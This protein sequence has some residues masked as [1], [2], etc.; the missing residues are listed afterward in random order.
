[1][2]EYAVILACYSPRATWRWWKR[3]LLGGL[4]LVSVD[5]LIFA[6]E[7]GSRAIAVEEADRKIIERC[8]I[9]KNG[10]KLDDRIL[11]SAF[12]PWGLHLVDVIQGG[13]QIGLCYGY[14]PL[15]LLP[16]ISAKITPQRPTTSIFRSDQAIPTQHSGNLQ[17]Y[18]TNESKAIDAQK[19]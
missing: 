3:V 18:R 13:S 12:C 11:T 17:C 7:A 19:K 5:G 10:V 2:S 9:W 14:S 4:G 6:S 15:L 1:M 8:L 16:Y